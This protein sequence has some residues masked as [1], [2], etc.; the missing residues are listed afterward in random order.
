M[1]P[2]GNSVS[3]ARKSF[4]VS[5]IHVY[6]RSAPHSRAPWVTLLSGRARV[7]TQCEAR[8]KSQRSPKRHRGRVSS[9]FRIHDAARCG[10]FNHRQ[11]LG[12]IVHF[13]PAPNH[14]FNLAIAA[15]TLWVGSLKQATREAERQ[16]AG[17]HR[18]LSH[19]VS[20]RSLLYDGGWCYCYT[21]KAT[22]SLMSND[23]NVQCGNVQ[24]R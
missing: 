8:C 22:I 12:K 4:S 24:C 13:N 14:H 21:W 19:R 2:G 20:P 1:Y 18:C 6:S 16:S 10:Q 15:H 5:S 7:T 3:A 17:D 11:P 9:M 23:L